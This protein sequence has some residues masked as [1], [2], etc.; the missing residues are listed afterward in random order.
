LDSS[1]PL[2]GEN[3]ESLKLSVSSLP[4]GGRAGFANDGYFGI[5]VTP[6]TTYHL[7]FYARADAGF[8]DPLTASLESSTGQVWARASIPALTSSWAKYTATLT[9]ARGIPATLENRLVITTSNPH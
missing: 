7:S 9:T 3:Q 2:N 8:A 1:Q 6:G 4:A 5:P